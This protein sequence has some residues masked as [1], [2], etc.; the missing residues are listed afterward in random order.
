MIVLLLLCQAQRGTDTA[1]KQELSDA[2]IRTGAW[3]KTQEVIA[4]ARKEDAT[5]WAYGYGLLVLCEASDEEVRRSLEQR[6]EACDIAS[7][8]ERTPLLV[9]A[10]WRQSEIVVR[11]ILDY[12]ELEEIAG[13]YKRMKRA[14]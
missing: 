9:R 5:Q 1:V 8:D 2:R 3:C 10:E 12:W 6:A 7:Q 13:R 14:A 11:A 4:R